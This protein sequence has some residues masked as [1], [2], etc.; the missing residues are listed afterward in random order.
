M[1]F[2]RFLNYCRDWTKVQSSYEWT[3][4]WG[5]KKR[6]LVV[7]EGSE[8]VRSYVVGRIKQMIGSP[9][10]SVY[11][12]HEIVDSQWQLLSD[13]RSPLRLLIWERKLLLQA[14][15]EQFIRDMGEMEGK[16]IIIDDSSELHDMFSTER[17]ESGKTF[18]NWTRGLLIDC[19]LTSSPLTEEK[20]LKEAYTFWLQEVEKIKLSPRLLRHFVDSPIL[21]SFNTIKG[22]SLLGEKDFNVL[23]AYKWGLLWVDRERELIQ[24]LLVKGRAAAKKEDWRDLNTERFFFMLVRELSTIMQ[25]KTIVVTQKDKF[26]KIGVSTPQY[27]RLKGV[28]KLHTLKELYRRLYLVSSL[29]KWRHHAS[30]VGLLLLHW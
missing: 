30:S 19:R 20:R 24:K 26:E 8:A 27:Y 1:N 13:R 12:L 25:I 9:V 4:P 15:A 22:L 10:T 28:A 7:C 18:R 2:R 23:T 14:E 3:S 6:V 5:E 16:T 21:E 29:M 17:L 11:F